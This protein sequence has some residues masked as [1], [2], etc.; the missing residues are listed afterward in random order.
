M[1]KY[2]IIISFIVVIIGCLGTAKADKAY[3]LVD[4]NSISI[5]D[6]SQNE[7]YFKIVNKE[8]KY[9]IVEVNYTQTNINYSNLLKED[10][11]K[12]NNI[13]NYSIVDN[14]GVMYHLENNI[15]VGSSMDNK[16]VDYFV[17]HNE[18]LKVI[19]KFDSK[20]NE[21]VIYYATVEV[22][23]G[24]N[25]SYY[26]NLNDAIYNSKEDSVI[27]LLNNQYLPE[28]IK[29]KNSITINGNGFVIDSNIK[30][31]FEVDK[32]VNTTAVITL[33]NVRANVNSFIKMNKN[34]FKV[35]NIN[36]SKIS[37]KVMGIDNKYSN[38]FNINS[39]TIFA[40]PL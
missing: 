16:K 32:Q 26:L 12:L 5:F 4:N 35:M 21:W 17:L 38:K 36:N 25:Y 27:N 30:Y 1:K 28:S 10:I 29:L 23:D 24:L 37:Y 13:N 20:N 19:F 9:G 18:D 39:N 14:N 2:L 6:D 15:L 40:L 34:N 33:N 11:V 3:D 8:N 31:L 22:V 7:S